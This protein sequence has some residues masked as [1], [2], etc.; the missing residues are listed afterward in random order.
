M[1]GAAVLLQ[2]FSCPLLCNPCGWNAEAAAAKALLP[3]SGGGSTIAQSSAH[4]KDSLRRGCFA[5]GGEAKGGRASMGRKGGREGGGG[6]GLSAE[7]DPPP[8]SELFASNG[9]RAGCQEGTRNVPPAPIWRRV[10]RW[11]EGAC[12]VLEGGGTCVWERKP[13][14]QEDSSG[15]GAGNEA[16]LPASL[17]QGWGVPGGARSGL[18]GGWRETRQLTEKSRSGGGLLS[19]LAPGLNCCIKPFSQRRT[20][21]VLERGRD[22]RS[23]AQ[24]PS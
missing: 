5:G 13:H 9:N 24:Q 6:G 20:E 8:S 15:G 19:P 16:L 2:R 11:E 10:K 23:V 18:G 21:A 1:P 4:P 17:C 7:A 14:E 12:S 22:R 3:T